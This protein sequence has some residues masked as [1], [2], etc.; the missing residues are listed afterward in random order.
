MRT[1]TMGT[2]KLGKEIQ[3]I[4]NNITNFQNPPIGVVKPTWDDNLKITPSW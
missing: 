3:T 2:M 4:S 1:L